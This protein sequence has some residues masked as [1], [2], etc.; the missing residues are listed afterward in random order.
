M[1]NEELILVVEQFKNGLM[2][3]ATGGSMLD[4]DYKRDRQ[5]LAESHLIKDILPQY[6]KTCRSSDEFWNFIKSKFSTY[7]E[8]RNFL[9]DDFSNIIYSL[10]QGKP[11]AFNNSDSYELGER[12]GHGGY[13]EVYKF[14]HTLLNID[15][16]VKILDPLFVSDEKNNEC[17]QRFFREAKMLFSLYHPNIVRFYD[18]GFY[19]GK[20]FIRMELV[21]GLNIA[22]FVDKHSI[23]SFER[24]KK[25]II[26]LLEGLSY[27]HANGIIHRDLKPSNFMVTPEGKFK[28]IDFGI[29]AYSEIAGHTKLTRTGESVAGGLYVDPCIMQDPQLRDARSDIYSVGAIWYFLLTG[30]A[31]GGG[32]MKDFLLKSAKITNL[33]TDIVMKCLS[34]DITK[35]YLTCDELLSKLKPEKMLT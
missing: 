27:A 34:Q 30:R 25:P 24:S 14:H 9:I 5:I 11:A 22:E 6:V 28:I 20:P 32:D 33:Q 26:E 35:R 2:S 18:V 4:S 12:L 19:M 16:A 1:I 13:C 29:S 31:P 15:F 17:I 7:Q 21:D 10:E 3:R 23:V 8:R